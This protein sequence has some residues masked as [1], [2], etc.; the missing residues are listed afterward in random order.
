MPPLYKITDWTT[1]FETNETRK[2]AVLRWI[3]KPNKHDGLGFGR[4][5]A[6]RDKVQLFCA[7]CLLLDVASKTTPRERRGFLERSGK[8]LDVE[9]LAYLTGF[10]SDIFTRALDFFSKSSVGWLAVEETSTGSTSADVL[11]QPPRP[12]ADTPIH[13]G[14]PPAVGKVGNGMESIEEKED[15][16]APLQKTSFVKPTIGEALLNC[17]KIGIPEA[18][19]EKFIAYYDSNGWRVGKN[20]MRSWQGAMINWRSNYDAKR[21]PQQG[22]GLADK[23]VLGKEYER[24]L[25][26][27]AA[28]RGQYSGMME[29]STEDKMEI[30]TLKDRKGVLMKILGI[31]I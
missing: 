25:A 13:L 3:P 29:W 22:S 21:A 16:V 12:L 23:I 14:Q 6:E 19:A 1:F 26:R 10:P 2:L 17:A 9:D 31:T 4:M 11:G 18:E 15:I 7:W 28:L 20:P 5:R 30:R 24:V 8:P 27:I